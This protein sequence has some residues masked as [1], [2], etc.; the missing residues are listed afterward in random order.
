MGMGNDQ[1]GQDDTKTAARAKKDVIRHSA[2]PMFEATGLSHETMLV[3][4]TT[5]VQKSGDV[6]CAA[7]IEGLP[8]GRTT[9]AAVFG[10]LDVSNPDTAGCW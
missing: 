4:V 10:A 6:D 2:S 9:V 8:R 7:L 1:D 5:G 3:Q